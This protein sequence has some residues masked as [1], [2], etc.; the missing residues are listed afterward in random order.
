ML[1]RPGRLAALALVLACT[2]V[3]PP[4]PESTPTP[5]E[6]PTPAA[7]VAPGHID[8]GLIY[9]NLRARTLPA[10]WRS[11]ALR[12]AAGG[13]IDELSA[14][15][16]VDLREVDPVTALG[17][18]PEG[19]ITATLMRP[20]GPL[21]AVR[22]GVQ[23]LAVP[24]PAGDLDFVATPFGGPSPP[25]LP[26]DLVRE[27]G[28]LYAHARVHFPAQEPEKLL[29]TFRA[30]H[31]AT[32]LCA[33]L[34]PQDVCS[35]A[36]TGIGLLRRQGD[37]VVADLFISAYPELGALTDPTRVAAITSALATTPAE[38]PEDSAVAGDLALYIHGPAVP[39][40]VDFGV[41]AFLVNRLRETHPAARLRQIQHSLGMRDAA[42]R[43]RDTRRLLSGLRV[44]VA[45]EPDV[46]IDLSWEP[47]DDEAARTVE[48]LFARPAVG[49]LS[50]PPVAALCHEALACGRLARLPAL[51]GF[52]PL[53]VGEYT[54]QGALDR[55]TVD[56]GYPLAA[57]VFVLETW[58][59]LIASLSRW[60]ERP[61][62]GPDAAAI[63]DFLGL[64][65]RIDSA[66]FRLA[67]ADDPSLAYARLGADELALVR[68]LAP[69]NG[70]ALADS[71]IAELPHSISAGS[72]A[73]V[74][75]SLATDPDAQAGW[76]VVA[77]DGAPVRWLLADVAHEPVSG[78]T[79]HLA[80]D[81]L[82]Q[83]ADALGLSGREFL[84]PLLAGR[85]LR[86]QT[87]ITAGRPRLELSLGSRAGD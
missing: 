27:A 67:R 5:A 62:A 12:M 87:G 26:D 8:G 52:G 81:D 69:L 45:L 39:A 2:P 86:L 85:S 34:P 20:I 18:D 54:D 66:G 61:D 17:L 56:A 51:A 41:H 74:T 1:A 25:P 28:S 24:H 29:R 72:I 71:P 47:V 53:A 82:G 3:S 83:L 78:P 38:L 73:G 32:G 60:H 16:G 33:L 57:L 14:A 15:V 7:I 9:L 64:A 68:A 46:R 49:G 21:A 6:G 30:P 37:A 42:L 10:L 65:E 63:H 48:G 58:P 84:R 76:F 80:S 19:T 55:L 50:A 79:L 11:P 44:T 75:A 77:Q 22:M 13:F 35:A 70:L 23:G 59:N 43:L 4:T 36:N 40:L 31:D